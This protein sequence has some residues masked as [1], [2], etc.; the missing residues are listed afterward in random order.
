MNL[1]EEI[2]RTLRLFTDNS[3]SKDFT[4]DFK[5]RLDYLMSK[6]IYQYAR[7]SSRKS[8]IEKIFNQFESTSK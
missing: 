2:H 5:K 7:R 4:L 8:K 6:K 3:A 1:T